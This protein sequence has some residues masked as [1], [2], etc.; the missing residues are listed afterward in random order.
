M[1]GNDRWCIAKQGQGMIKKLGALAVG[2]VNVS[3]SIAVAALASAIASKAEKLGELQARL[4]AIAA[5]PFMPSP[6]QLSMQSALAIASYSPIS[7]LAQLAKL[8]PQI[9]AEIAAITASISA[10]QSISATLGSAIATGGVYTYVY[11]GQ[12]GNI[13][14]EL[15]SSI[16][17]DMSQTPINA[18]VLLTNTQAA[19]AAIQSVIKTQ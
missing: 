10:S 6:A 18:V 8:L 7:A 13:G 17:S 12:S 5:P 19:W 16:D 15:Q 1:R 4:T 14:A 3:A 2:V 11:N 9:N